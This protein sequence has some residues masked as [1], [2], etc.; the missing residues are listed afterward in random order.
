MTQIPNKIFGGA[1]AHTG[2]NDL[3][4]LWCG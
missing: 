4:E 1:T 2:A 3:L